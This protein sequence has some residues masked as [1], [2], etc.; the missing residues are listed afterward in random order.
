VESQQAA[1]EERSQ[2]QLRAAESI[3]GAVESQQAALEER[4]QGQLRAAES[5]RQAVESQQAA[6][7]EKLQEQIR[8]AASLEAEVSFQGKALSM[9]TAVTVLFLPLSF[10]AQV[11]SSC[12]RANHFGLSLTM[13]QL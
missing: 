7:D 3:R 11:I 2:E 8:L 9:F 1:L 5:I 13:N 12:P 4:M 6:H 10:L